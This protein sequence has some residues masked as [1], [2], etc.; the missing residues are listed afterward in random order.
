MP[1]SYYTKLL[2]Q[3]RREGR[4]E[5]RDDSRAALAETLATAL[6]SRLGDAP[7]DGLARVR[8]MPEAE[9]HTCL[10][11]LLEGDDPRELIRGW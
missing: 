3:G 7:T 4:Q 11:R 9:L 8:A 2:R 5:G 6:R 10:R 1:M